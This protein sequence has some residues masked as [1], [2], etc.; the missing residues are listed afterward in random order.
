MLSSQLSQLVFSPLKYFSPT[1]P[2]IRSCERTVRS[3]SEISPPLS[4]A[5]RVSEAEVAERARSLERE[6]AAWGGGWGG[7]DE[8]GGLGWGG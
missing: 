8:G 5:R 7:G 2:H 6:R 4:S 1:F 3:S